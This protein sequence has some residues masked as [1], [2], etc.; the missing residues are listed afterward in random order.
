[1]AELNAIIG[2]I[3]RELAQARYMS[4]TYSR[5]LSRIY[6][7]DAL[8]RLFPVPRAEVQDVE[9]C[10]KFAISNI[11]K[12]AHDHESTVSKIFASH[13]ENITKDLLDG[14]GGSADFQEMYPEWQTV[15]SNLLSQNISID[16][17]SAI[18]TALEENSSSLINIS[19][20]GGKDDEGTGPETITAHRSKISAIISETIERVIFGRKDVSEAVKKLDLQQYPDGNVPSRRSVESKVKSSMTGSI[21]DRIDVLMSAL[22]KLEL[23]DLFILDV[24]VTKDTLQELPES[25]LTELTI[26]AQ[27][28]NYNWLQVDEKDNKAVRKLQPE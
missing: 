26:K 23:E 9:L 18:L 19:E 24:D 6:E 22:E 15:V 17:Q 28:R 25:A 4:D 3:L 27:V 11:K 21:R 20:E 13:V 1:M 2:T 14:L 10:L 8:L 5:N 7:R 12:I 16:L